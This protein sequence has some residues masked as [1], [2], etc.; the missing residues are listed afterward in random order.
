MVR[1]SD[2]GLGVGRPEFGIW[3]CHLLVVFLPANHSVFLR[4]FLYLQNTRIE[5]PVNA[6]C[7]PIL[8]SVDSV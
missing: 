4:W 8:K 2:N 3:F 1:F 7:F 6:E 5:I